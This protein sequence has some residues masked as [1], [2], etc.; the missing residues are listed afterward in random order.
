MAESNLQATDASQAAKKVEPPKRIPI[1]LENSDLIPLSGLPIGVNGQTY[2]L[3][4]GV[5]AEVPKEVLEVLKNAVM[6]VPVQDPLTGQVVRYQ[7]K[8]RYPYQRLDN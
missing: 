5:R 2:L 8:L 6:S 7:D 4:A 1:M 3:R